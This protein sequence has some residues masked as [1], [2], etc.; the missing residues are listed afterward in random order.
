MVLEDP[1]LDR[2]EV[3][4]VLP[5]APPMLL[6]DRVLEGSPE[7]VVAEK[8]FPADSRYFEGHFPDRPVLP[9]IFLVEAM[10][11]ACLILYAYNYELDGNFFMGKDETSYQRSVTPDTTV[12]VRATK[13]R[14]LPD[15]GIGD[16]KAYHDGDLLA[17]SRMHF[18]AEDFALGGKSGD[19]PD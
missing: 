19:E 16:A 9:G 3:A 4:S 2:E 8:D 11:Q 6:I 14:Y 5:Q 17:E 13:E 10:A 12:R 1:R 15:A 18:A 7:E